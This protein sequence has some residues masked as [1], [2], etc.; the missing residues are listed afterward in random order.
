MESCKLWWGEFTGF[1]VCLFASQIGNTPLLKMFWAA[2][3]MP[4]YHLSR[5]PV[6]VLLKELM[7]VFLCLF[8]RKRG[9]VP[10]ST[11]AGKW[12]LWG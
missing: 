8:S 9:S 7:G 6:V 3:G 10:T 2:L 4:L 1:C 12:S 11:P 5:I